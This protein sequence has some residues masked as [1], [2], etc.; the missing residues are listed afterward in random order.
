MT[1]PIH[2]KKSHER[3]LLMAVVITTFTVMALFNL[4]FS[5]LVFLI[6]SSYIILN[7]NQ[8][9]TKNELLIEFGIVIPYL[10]YCIISRMAGRG[11]GAFTALILVFF[12]LM[13]YLIVWRFR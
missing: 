3:N 6:A 7:K 10:I 12:S 5:P 2:L 9:L 11:A 4:Y 1:K 13:A 8:R